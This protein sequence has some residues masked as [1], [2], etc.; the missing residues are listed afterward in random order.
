MTAKTLEI[1]IICPEKKL[2]D[3]HKIG[4]PCKNLYPSYKYKIHSEKLH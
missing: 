4:L 1:P 3:Y 2:L